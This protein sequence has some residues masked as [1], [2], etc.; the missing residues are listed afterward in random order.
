MFKICTIASS[1]KGNC[2]FIS[3]GKTNI[4]VDCGIKAPALEAFFKSMDLSLNDISAVVIT[5]EHVDH[6]CGLKSLSKKCS[7]KIYCHEFVSRL[8]SERL[9]VSLN[10]ENFDIDGFTIGDIKV[11][12]IKISHDAVCPFGYTFNEG[13]K[14]ISYLTDLGVVTPNIIDSLKDSDMAII[15]SNHDERMLIQGNYPTMLKKRVD[16]VMGHL[17]NDEA[18]SLINELCS[19]NLKKVILAHLSE[20]NNLPELAYSTVTEYL[21]KNGKIEGR[22]YLLKVAPASL[23]SEFLED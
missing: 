16:G 7:P 13:N 10:F 12:P 23:P 18:A 14:S 19:H 2:S 6:I 17:S 5:H 9:N 3:D 20:N 4:L 21:E 11:K 1:S 22:D 15:E 8:I